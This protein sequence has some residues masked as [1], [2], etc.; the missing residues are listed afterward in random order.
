MTLTA[1]T[2][3]GSMLTVH[4]QELSKE[5]TKPAVPEYK[6]SEPNVYTCTS[7]EISTIRNEMCMMYYVISK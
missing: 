7:S 4:G 6:S 3:V 2:Q 5:P 1:M